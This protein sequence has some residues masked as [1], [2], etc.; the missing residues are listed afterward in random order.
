MQRKSSGIQL[1]DDLYY[2]G[3]MRL[4][5]R[6]LG[7]SGHQ[8]SPLAKK[9]SCFSS[10]V[11]RQV[12]K[13]SPPKPAA[14]Q[15]SLSVKKSCLVLVE[16]LD[17]EE[18]VSARKRTLNERS[19]K[20]SSDTDY[21]LPEPKAKKVKYPSLKARAMAQMHAIGEGISVRK[22]TIPDAGNGLFADQ[23]FEEG[24]FITW[25]D[26]IVED[27]TPK[28]RK[29]LLQ[30]KDVTVWS[31]IR[32]VNQNRVVHGYQDPKDSL[33]GGSFMNDGFNAFQPANVEIVSM[34][35]EHSPPE[36]GEYELYVRAKRPIEKGEE[37]FY[38]YSSACWK[39]F[40]MDEP[41]FYEKHFA[42]QIRSKATLRRLVESCDDGRLQPLLDALQGTP[43]PYWLELKLHFTEWTIELCRYALYKCGAC[44]P[45]ILTQ[46]AMR[47]LK[48]ETD[49][50][51]KA[52]GQY[53]CSLTARSTH[54]L[55]KGGD[56]KDRISE[57]N[58]T[59]RGR[60][61]IKRQPVRIPDNGV[62]REPDKDWR[63]GHIQVFYYYFR[64]VNFYTDGDRL[65]HILQVLHP[66]HPLYEQLSG[67][68]L[69]RM[70]DTAA[71]K[72]LDFNCPSVIKKRNNL[73]ATLLRS[74][75]YMPV[76]VDTPECEWKKWTLPGIRQNLRAHG[77]KVI[78][79][80]PARNSPWKILDSVF[81]SG[82]DEEYTQHLLKMCRSRGCEFATITRKSKVSHCGCG[83]RFKDIDGLFYKVKDKKSEIAAKNFC[84][85][86]ALFMQYIQRA[87]FDCY[88]VYKQI[89]NETLYR[90]LDMMTPEYLRTEKG[91]NMARDFVAM[92]ICDCVNMKSINRIFTKYK[93]HLSDE[94]QALTNQK[95]Y[96]ALKPIGDRLLATYAELPRL[97]GIFST[98]AAAEASGYS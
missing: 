10:Q 2:H 97:K 77:V 17:F 89:T 91:K 40:S 58:R 94:L 19:S 4:K 31:H 18:Y 75:L 82:T 21:R 72:L 29:E 64:R 7:Q 95:R 16:P 30:V 86:H 81:E 62:F 14:L 71:G 88:E 96:E 70:M 3:S 8:H 57:W 15:P 32:G 26:G 83:I 49:A 53:V 41:E 61:G 11:R 13:Q 80:D 74:G 37:L 52:L 39:R 42:C 6:Q 44:E 92:A 25:Y 69:F 24:E 67:Q 55:T 73:T 22:S 46:G 68:Y 23:V 35:S 36:P 66:A 60:D 43:V 63:V 84:D 54:A 28:R 1:N 50:Y 51:F 85:K 76:T 20:I 27:I 78:E 93:G 5:A 12:R 59:K 65:M 90:C 56:A 98:E 38:D 9:A 47:L 48:K 34:P 33:G 45:G 87:G 79:P